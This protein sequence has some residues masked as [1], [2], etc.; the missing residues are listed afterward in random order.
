MSKKLKENQVIAAKLI[1]FGFSSRSV[2]KWI[3]V[4][5]ETISRWKAQK[6]F[7]EEIQN[8]QS[9]TLDFIKEKHFQL[10]IKSLSI[11][12]KALEDD[13]LSLK[14]KAMISTRYLSL[15]SG[16]LINNINKSS[17]HIKENSSLNF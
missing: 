7:L 2:S 14:D 11:I 6:V 9:D 4:R 3:N 13:D 15:S 8:Q 12:E 1:S 5:E 16:Y 10:F 17:Y